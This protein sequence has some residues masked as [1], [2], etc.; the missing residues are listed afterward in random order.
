LLYEST[1]ACLPKTDINYRIAI[2]INRDELFVL[3]ALIDE[4]IE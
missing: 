4:V 1:H 2:A 3:I